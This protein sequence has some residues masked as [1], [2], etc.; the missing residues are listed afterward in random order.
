MTVF[1]LIRQLTEFEAGKEVKFR[2]KGNSEKYDAFFNGYAYID[3][4]QSNSER[5]IF[6]LNLEIDEAK[7]CVTCNHRCR[8]AFE[9]ACDCNKSELFYS[10]IDANDSCDEWEERDV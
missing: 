10:Q 6:G 7:L 3:Y 8:G 9:W 1:D 2:V 4:I 5:V